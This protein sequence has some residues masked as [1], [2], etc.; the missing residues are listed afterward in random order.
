MIKC[1]NFHQRNIMTKD[2][3]SYLFFD[4]SLLNGPSC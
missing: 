1:M 4:I 2:Y 3:F